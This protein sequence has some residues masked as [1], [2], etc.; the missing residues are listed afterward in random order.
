MYN[1]YDCYDYIFP[2]MACGCE[3]SDYGTMYEI[4]DDFCKH[5]VI[6]GG[7]LDDLIWSLYGYDI[8][9]DR[10]A[11][12]MG[13]E[14]VIDHESRAFHNMEELDLRWTNEPPTVWTDVILY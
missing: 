11:E 3:Q 14:T 5:A 13:W 8:D 12:L 4:G 7:C 2:T 9:G 6:C 10:F 1:D